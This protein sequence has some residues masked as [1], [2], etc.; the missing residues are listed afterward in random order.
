MRKQ[1][2]TLNSQAKLSWA[3][4]QKRENPEVKKED[5]EA[6]KEA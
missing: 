2:V 3:T 4:K 1:I 5:L 6:G